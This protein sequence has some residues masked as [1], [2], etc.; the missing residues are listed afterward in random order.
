MHRKDNIQDYSGQSQ[1]WHVDPVYGQNSPQ[2]P[3]L[4]PYPHPQSTPMDQHHWVPTL[5]SYAPMGH[6]TTPQQHPYP[7]NISTQ[8]G[9]QM[10]VNYSPASSSGLHTP[11]FHGTPSASFSH[12]AQLP[13]RASP[14][15]VY[16]PLD[17]ALP[18]NVRKAIQEAYAS[19][20]YARGDNVPAEILLPTVRKVQ[21]DSWI[22]LICEKT[23]KRR[24]HTLTHVR[25]AHLQNKGYRCQYEGCDS[26][27]GRKGDLERHEASTHEK[28]YDER[29]PHCNTQ[30]HRKD[31]LA[32]HKRSCR[33]RGQ[34]SDDV[35][36]SSGPSSPA[37]HRAKNAS[38]TFY[39]TVRHD[40]LRGHGHIL[41]LP[42]LTT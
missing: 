17:D 32:R 22:C 30:L 29:C 2:L 1:A 31:N 5:P 27:F 33:N 20:E 6:L 34:Y 10:H 16:P 3:P 28:A 25:T 18:A 38:G 23:H 42:L 13:A 4:P 40:P 9:S 15:A 21:D 26:A 36:P 19:P 7:Y 24:D 39:S 41:A 37:R 35:L 11:A 8:G 14:P 12:I